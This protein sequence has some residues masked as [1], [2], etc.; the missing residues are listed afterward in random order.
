MHHVFMLTVG[1]L[2]LCHL[3]CMSRLY[4]C[5]HSIH[6]RSCIS[7]I[8]YRRQEPEQGQEKVQ[9][10]ARES[11]QESGVESGQE[12][13]QVSERESERESGLE[14]GQETEQQSERESGQETEQKSE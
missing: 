14:S 2:K 7:Q 9:V 13:V 8:S 10:S 1:V 11:G 6:Y 5:C 12:K 3:I 4:I